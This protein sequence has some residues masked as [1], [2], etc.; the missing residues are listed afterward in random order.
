MECHQMASCFVVRESRGV[1]CA[2]TTSFV[3]CQTKNPVVCCIV[4]SIDS[5]RLWPCLDTLTRLEVRVS[6]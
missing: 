6:F 4:R 1:Q 3:A 5:V 2:S